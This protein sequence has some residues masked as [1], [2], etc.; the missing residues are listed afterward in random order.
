MNSKQKLLYK[1]IANILWKNWDPIGVYEADAD[2]SDEYDSYVPHIYRL[3]LKGEDAVRI[4]QSLTLSA[5][6]NIGFGASPEHDLFVAKLI[7]KSKIEL[8][9]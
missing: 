1:S 5:T 9:G 3:A 7:I 8:L 2:W 6:Q 4:A